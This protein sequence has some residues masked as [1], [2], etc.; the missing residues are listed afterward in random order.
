MERAASALE[1]VFDP[2]PGEALNGLVVEHVVKVNIARTGIADWHPM[3]FFLKSP[4]GEWLGGVTGHVWGGW[5]HVDFLWV[6]ETLRGQGHGCGRGHGEG[7]RRGYGNAGDIHVPGAG[8]LCET[9]LPS[10]WAP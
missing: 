10:V 3:G 9:R 7:A 4:R 8:F 2:L 6:S 5:L 1:I